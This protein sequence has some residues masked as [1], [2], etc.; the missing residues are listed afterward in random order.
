MSFLGLTFERRY[1]VSG[2]DG[3]MRAMTADEILKMQFE[4]QRAMQNAWQEYHHNSLSYLSMNFGYA[5]PRPLD[6]RFA[7]FKTRLAAAIA[8]RANPS[9]T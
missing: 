6:E 5:P 9:Q 3:G 2:F 8:K 1:P 7:E 4:Q